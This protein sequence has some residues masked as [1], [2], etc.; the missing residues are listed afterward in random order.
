M[1]GVYYV[2]VPTLKG[3]FLT[4]LKLKSPYERGPARFLNIRVSQKY[5]VFAFN[6]L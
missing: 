6:L 3:E 4:N 1:Q 5:I 2:K